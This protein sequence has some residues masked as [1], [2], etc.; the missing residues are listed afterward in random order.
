[1]E[2]DLSKF[3]RVDLPVFL[4]SSSKTMEFKF[5]TKVIG[6]RRGSFIA[7]KTPVYRGFRVAIPQDVDISVR[8]F[9][10]GSLFVFTTRVSFYISSPLFVTFVFY[11]E[12][13]DEIKVRRYDRIQVYIPVEAFDEG[14]RVEGTFLDL[15]LGGALF[16]SKEKF[17]QGKTLSFSF[18]LPSGDKVTNAL[19][20]VRS[21]KSSDSGFYL[22]GLKFV[23]MSADDEKRMKRFF[24]EVKRTGKE[25]VIWV[26]QPL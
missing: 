9:S 24:E 25:G 6:W 18:Y 2:R 12:T 22:H 20:E 10:E 16:V 26:S 8:F 13:Y 7:L 21:V 11:P 4:E 17:E 3:L 23:R 5:H 19:G 1:M 15:S 14:R